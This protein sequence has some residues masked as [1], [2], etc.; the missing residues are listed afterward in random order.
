MQKARDCDFF[1][2]PDKE[3]SAY[4][5]RLMERLKDIDERRHVD[6]DRLE[7]LIERK[8]KKQYD[9]LWPKL[10]LGQNN[11]KMFWATALGIILLLV[12]Y[13]SGYNGSRGTNLMLK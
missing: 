2:W 4:E 11:G 8:C 3:M 7:K 1:E 12:F 10:G 6:N 13:V 5:M 9:K